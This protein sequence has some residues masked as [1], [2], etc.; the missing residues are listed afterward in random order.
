VS[1]NGNA[2]PHRQRRA[3]IDRLTN[4]V[5]HTAYDLLTHGHRSERTIQFDLLTRTHPVD[6]VQGSYQCL[7][8]I[9]P[10]H[11]ALER[12]VVWSMDLHHCTYWDWEAIDDDRCAADAS[13]LAE[14]R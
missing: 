5:D 6:V 7:A 11:L 13:Y 10:D 12:L 8:S 3:I 9:E 4:S 1:V 2:P 14:D